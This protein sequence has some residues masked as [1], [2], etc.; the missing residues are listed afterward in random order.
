MAGNARIGTGD[1]ATA[2]NESSFLDD[3]DFPLSAPVRPPPGAWVG[4]CVD[5]CHPVLRGRARVRWEDAEG[6]SHTAWFPCLASL[7][8]RP[9]DRVLLSTP[10]N[11]DE[12]VITGVIDGFHPRPERPTRAGAT[13]ALKADEHLAITDAE[14]NPLVEVR[15]GA[16]GPVVR[17]LH[18]ATTLDLPGALT[19]RADA[20]ALAARRGDLRV[21]AQGDV[22]VRG[23]TIRLNGT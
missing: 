18:A 4:L 5:A 8:L 7:A 11:H 1:G 3:L 20:I 21:E 9:G 23:A 12:A 2:R 17:V 16:E 19:I 10:A 22:R 15:Q 14:G 6:A 13:L